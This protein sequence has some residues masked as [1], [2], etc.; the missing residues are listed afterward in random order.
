MNIK[1]TAITA[2]AL[3]LFPVL[4]HAEGNG[5]PENSTL[6]NLI[7]GSAPFLIL[8]VLFFWFFRRIQSSKNPRIRKYDEHMAREVQ[9]MERVEQSL[10]RIA[11][12][13]EKK[14]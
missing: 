5:S 12:L 4:A 14:D 1:H 7:W 8:G 13:L 3:L 9:H 2:T 11:K 10:E 6:S